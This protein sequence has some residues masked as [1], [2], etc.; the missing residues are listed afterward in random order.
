MGPRPAEFV[1][2]PDVRGMSLEEATA[3]LEELGLVAVSVEIYTSL[4]P[5][6]ELFAQLPPPESSVAPGSTVYLGI[7]KGPYPVVNPL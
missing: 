1:I 3:T 7:S 6:G 5:Q 4:A 2:V